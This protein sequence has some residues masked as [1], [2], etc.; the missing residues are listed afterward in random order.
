M[1][2]GALSHCDLT[3]TDP[4]RAIPFYDAV[5]PLLGYRRVPVEP[6]TTAVACWSLTDGEQSVF[7]IALE[8]ARGVGKQRHYD[9]AAPGLHHLAFHLDSRADVDQCYA[10]LVAVGITILDPPAEYAYTPGYYALSC[11]DPDGLVLECV[12]EPQHR[13]TLGA[14][15]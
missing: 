11:Q 13:G 15:R 5:L 1:I 7:S 2:R 9:R 4:A 3:I 14:A 6:G 8:R 10:Q 12:Y